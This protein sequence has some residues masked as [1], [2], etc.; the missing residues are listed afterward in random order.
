MKNPAATATA[1]IAIFFSM[2]R[3]PFPSM[4]MFQS[5]NSAARGKPRPVLLFVGNDAR[6]GK[7]AGLCGVR[8]RGAENLRHVRNMPPQICHPAAEQAQKLGRWTGPTVRGLSCMHARQSGW[9]DCF[10]QL[11]IAKSFTVVM[12]LLM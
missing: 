5:G 8:F 9:P 4:K 11:V 7:N 3:N 6:F 12:Q 1:A 2:M 10:M